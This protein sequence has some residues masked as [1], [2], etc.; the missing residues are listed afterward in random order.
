MFN[1]V[2]FRKNLVTLG[3][4]VTALATSGAIADETVSVSKL[5]KTLGKIVREVLQSHQATPN[6]LFKALEFKIDEKATIL[7]N[8]DKFATRVN[9]KATASRARWSTDGDTTLGV[10]LA[11]SAD[12]LKQEATL[13]LA[14][15]LDTDT[16][17]LVR[18]AASELKSEWCKPS[19][20]ASEL[21]AE[22]CTAMKSLEV[23]KNIDQVIKVITG[24]GDLAVKDGAARVKKAEQELA[25]APDAQKKNYQKLLE[26]AQKDLKAADTIASELRRGAVAGSA[27]GT[28]RLSFRDV[29]AGIGELRDVEVYL[30]KNRFEAKLKFTMKDIKDI[31]S[32]FKMKPMVLD[33]LKKLE[34]DN[35]EEVEDA[36]RFLELYLNIAG[37]LIE[38]K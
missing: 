37:S 18:F 29:D 26:S 32:Y 36:K 34:G 25:A 28:L 21:D 13:E 24:L 35:K 10:D 9:L 2:M 1:G 19:K 31:D 17:G 15:N 4:V 27:N 6:P 5:N 12:R 30:D 14:G 38:G 3:V 20:P 33:V 11:M 23:A 7:D 8:D 16:V 22:Y